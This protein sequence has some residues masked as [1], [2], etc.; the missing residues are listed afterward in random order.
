MQEMLYKRYRPQ[1]FNNFFGNSHVITS[2]KNGII[3]GKVS[4]AFMFSGS[5]GTGKT[6]LARLIAKSLSCEQPIDGYNPCLKCSNCISIAK[7]KFPDMIEIDAASNRGIEDIRNIKDSVNYKPLIGKFKFY[8]IDEVHMLTKEAF[9]ALLKT[10][11]EP[12]KH[13]I[14]ILATTEPD[15]VLETIKSRCERHDLKLLDS[16]SIHTR[17]KDILNLEKRSM[18][19]ESIDLIIRESGSSMRDALSLLEK[20]L[21]FIPEDEIKRESYE[22]ALGVIPSAI[23]SKF[24]EYYLDGNF[25][26]M[27]NIVDKAW[28][29]GYKIDLLM[30]DLAYLIKKESS[31]SYK[32]IKQISKIYSSINEFRLEEN[33]RAV[34]YVILSRLFEDIN[35]SQK[36]YKSID[37]KISKESSASNES[38]KKKLYQKDKPSIVEGNESKTT[39]ES[40]SQQINK[41]D[42]KVEDKAAV[43]KSKVDR[44]EDSIVFKDGKSSETHSTKN[45]TPS[46]RVE[47]KSFSPSTM[48][49]KAV[50][51]KISNNWDQLLKDLKEESISVMIFLLNAQL[52]NYEGGKLTLKYDKG[53]K[54]H[55]ESL[56]RSENRIILER[57]L[58]RLVGVS[59][60]ISLEIDKDVENDFKSKVDA[61]LEGN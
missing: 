35:R 50:F 44:E 60:N 2:I 48:E 39:A 17:I 52:V 25:D 57:A 61:I 59:V 41:L 31:D 15:K 24:Y 16:H 58:S 49:D 33:K 5:R 11:E 4:H 1:D 7:S 47:K 14:F 3:R 43:N 6:T 46:L 55:K 18:D 30:K 28:L 32:S 19:D 13:V 53:H 37:T 38:N 51:N 42:D 20:V 26:E 56:E 12:P 8:I 45:H 21:T 23:I 36:D 9:N 22:E 54:F 27:V 29:E 10:L 34:G 40:D